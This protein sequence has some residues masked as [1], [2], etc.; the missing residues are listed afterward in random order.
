MQFDLGMMGL[1]RGRRTMDIENRVVVIAGATGA[2]GR[3]SPG[4]LPRRVR[5][6]SWWEPAKTS[7][8]G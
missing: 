5:V 1:R 4:N 8:K 2:L 6:W 7:S 3:G